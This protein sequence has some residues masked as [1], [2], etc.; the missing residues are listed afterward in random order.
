MQA[1]SLGKGG[2]IFILDMGKPVRIVDMANDMIMMMGY[3]H[4]RVKIEYTGLKNGE[5]LH[6]ELLINEAEKKTNYESITVAGVT[7]VNWEEF[8]G[9]INELI[10]YAS[11]ANV[12]ASIRMLKKLVSE[13]NPE[14]EAYK[15][16]L[17]TTRLTP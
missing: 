5:K 14:N 15:T 9:D 8:E 17:K 4:E 3:N 13:Y 11:E 2:E 7:D 1:A 6:E 12:D 10:R 16:V